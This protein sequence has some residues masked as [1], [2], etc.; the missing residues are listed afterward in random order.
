[1][2]LHIRDVDTPDSPPWGSLP[3]D[4]YLLSEWETPHPD[5]THSSETPSERRSRLIRQFIQLGTPGREPYNC[6]SPPQPTDAEIAEILRPARPEALRPYA[7]FSGSLEEGLWLRLSYD[8]KKKEQH[9]AVWAENIDSDFVGPDGI[10]LDDKEI[11]AGADLARALEIFPER[12]TNEDSDIYLERR[13][14]ALRE[15]RELLADSDVEDEGDWERDVGLYGVY[16]SYCV[17]THLFIEDEQALDGGGLLHVF[18]DDCGNMVRQWRTEN[19][20]GDDNYD[21]AWKSGIL[22]EAFSYGRGEVGAAY[23]PGGVRGPPYA[24]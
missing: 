22:K 15:L 19:D 18:L 20:G 8:E 6:R 2:P 1:M 10:V 14:T 17:V 3:L 4:V 5:P 11:F 21:G 13:D 9:R 7:E 12:V 16:H 24:L 23:R